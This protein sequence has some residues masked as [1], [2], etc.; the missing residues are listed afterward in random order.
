MSGISAVSER[1]RHYGLRGS[2]NETIRV[3][4]K[5]VSLDYSHIWYEL[6]LKGDRP[7]KSLSSELTLI[8]ASEDDLP[9]IN[10]LPT[11]R[12]EAARRR[13][14]A[15]NDLWL[16]LKERQPVF[17]CWI[18]YSSVPTQVARNAGLELPPG[19]VCLEDSV[20]S[21]T[22]RGKGT[23]AATWSEVADNLEQSGATTMITLIEDGNKAVELALRKGGFKEIARTH[24][25]RKGVREQTVIRAEPCATG[26]WLARELMY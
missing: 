21:P 13:M 18:L 17:A 5:R 16:V 1:L 8:K 20:A 2:V 24:F 11:L 14:R 15:G 19:I 23:A 22:Y 10:E 6:P 9:L 26:E 4:R 12:E 3:A 7:R 25:L